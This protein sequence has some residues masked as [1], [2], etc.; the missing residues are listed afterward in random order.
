M[1]PLLWRM[2]SRSTKACEVWRGLVSVKAMAEALSPIPFQAFDLQA[3]FT[4]Y[5]SRLPHWRQ[6]GCTYFVTFRLADALPK[7]A[8]ERLLEDYEVFLRHH[9]IEPDASDARECYLKVDVRHRERYEREYAVKLNRFL[10]AS[11][12]GCELAQP[13]CA[14]ALRDCLLRFDG[15]KVAV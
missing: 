14:R 6:R 4:I 8:I 12:G 10:D 11:H 15:I 9:G 1:L 3:P 2:F 7:E 5:W 13:A